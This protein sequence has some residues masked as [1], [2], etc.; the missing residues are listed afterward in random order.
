MNEY[1]SL[2][3]GA[4]LLYWPYLWCWYRKEDTADYGLVPEYSFKVVLQT[5]AVS[6]LVLSLLTP[7]ALYWPGD[8]LPHK[9]N[10]LQIFKFMGA[11]LAAAIIEETFFRG[12]LQTMIKK[13][14]GTAAAVVLTNCIFAPIHLIA[15]PHWISLTTFFPGIIMGTLKEKYGNI[16]PSIIFHFLGNVWSIWFFPS[17]F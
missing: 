12:W 6:A 5:L 2:A 4:A 10:A 9:R 1:L 16:M 11:G 8:N 7:V 13:R 15:S 3:V 17:S 14:C